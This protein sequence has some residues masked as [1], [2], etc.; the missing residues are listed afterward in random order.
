MNSEILSESIQELDELFNSLCTGN[1]TDINYAIGRLTKIKKNSRF[2]YVRDRAAEILDDPFT[3]DRLDDMI[4]NKGDH[5]LGLAVDPNQKELLDDAK[6]SSVFLMDIQDLGHVYRNKSNS[7]AWRLLDNI[8]ESN[9]FPDKIRDS[10]GIEL[11][12]SWAQRYIQI[13]PWKSEALIA[14]VAALI[15]AGFVEIGI[16][17]YRHYSD[18]HG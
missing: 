12:Y 8:F 16:E 13:H 17:I 3:H 7:V 18:S 15:A 10:A 11:G 2:V 4:R 14:L 5:I 1:E 9:S 6:M